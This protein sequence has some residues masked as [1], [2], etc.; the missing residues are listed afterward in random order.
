MNLEIGRGAKSLNHAH[1]AGVRLSWRTEK[2]L[3]VEGIVVIILYRVAAHFSVAVT[4]ASD[5]PT[6]RLGA[7]S[8]VIAP[9]SSFEHKS[10]PVV[11]LNLCFKQVF[12]LA[13]GKA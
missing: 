4:A 13:C 9:V 12:P 5:I 7:V 2:I 6:K 11:F 8:S 3:I 1:R 10:L